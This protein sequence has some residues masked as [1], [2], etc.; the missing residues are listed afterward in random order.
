MSEV[1]K[2]TANARIRIEIEVSAGSTWGTTTQLEQVH[3]Q[4]TQGAIN[5]LERT[6]INHGEG[7]IRIVGEPKVLTVITAEEGR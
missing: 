4:A 2:V 5:F 7:R 1:K 3:H 6:L